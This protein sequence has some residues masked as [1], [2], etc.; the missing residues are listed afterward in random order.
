MSPHSAPVHSARSVRCLR[1]PFI[2]LDFRHPRDLPCVGR[3]IRLVLEVRKFF[4]RNPGC[5]R[6]PCSPR[7]SQISL[8]PPLA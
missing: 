7:D 2:V 6:H 1:L 4:C 5:S 3:P 8:K